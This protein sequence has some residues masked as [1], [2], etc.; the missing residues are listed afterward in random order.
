MQCSC[1]F[2]KNPTGI[3]SG[4]GRES[5]RTAGKRVLPMLRGSNS[6]PWAFFPEKYDII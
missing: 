5:L 1:S 4:F 3:F 6:G 2:L